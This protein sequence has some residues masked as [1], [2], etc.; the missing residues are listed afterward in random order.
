[1]LGR[2]NEA[3][4]SAADVVI[5]FITLN[6]KPYFLFYCHIRK[7][8]FLLQL[9]PPPSSLQSFEYHWKHVK[10]FYS[11]NSVLPKV[12]IENTNLPIHLE[13]M[14]KLLIDEDN[15]H[16]N[17]PIPSTVLDSSSKSNAGPSRDCFRFVLTNRPF[18]LL[19]DIC[20]TDSP[21]GAS[22]C[23]LNWMRRFLT[24]LEQPR[25]DHKSILQPIQVIFIPNESKFEF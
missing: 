23:I 14:L 11:S 21:P 19:T 9:A 16:R 22:V 8:Y 18:D 4:Q 25:L 3:L 13:G 5:Y 10:N 17:E 15:L 7:I 6:H 12:H 24:C 2:F 20:L 1:M